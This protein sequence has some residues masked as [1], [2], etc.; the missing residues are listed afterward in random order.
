[1]R[2]IRPP[3]PLDLDS[4]S[5]ELQIAVAESARC[6]VRLFI[7][8]QSSVVDAAIEEAVIRGGEC[9]LPANCCFRKSTQAIARAAEYA[10]IREEIVTEENGGQGA[11]AA[12]HNDFQLSH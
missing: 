10:S 5:A 4:G 8:N 9:A 7:L 11:S 2:I 6:A 1:M 3:P 12:R